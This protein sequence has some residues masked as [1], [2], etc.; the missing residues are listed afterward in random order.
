MK[1][2]VLLLF[3]CL[4][5]AVTFAQTDNLIKEKDPTVA[6]A[7]SLL[8]YAYN[9][10]EIDLDIR[11]K[12]RQWL[13]IAP[14]MQYGQPSEYTYT[15]MNTIKNGLGLGLNYRYFPLNRMSYTQS[16]GIGPFVSAGLRGQATLYDY[17]GNRYMLYTDDYGIDGFYAVG[18][19]SYEEWVSQLSVDICLGYS[20]RMFDV[21]YLEASIGLGSRISNYTYDERKGFDL[22]ENSWDTGFS[23]Y[24]LTGGIRL[25]IFL[26]KY[27]R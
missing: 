8:P 26:D 2:T 27:T 19:Q 10:A 1:Q 22:G 7:F 6:L 12:E 14:R 18:D 25:G 15:P 20:L 5:T 16:D 11:L 9:T 4:I 21:I 24:T 13:T 23:G 3:A 17:T